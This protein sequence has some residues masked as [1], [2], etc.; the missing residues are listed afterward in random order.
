MSE[1]RQDLKQPDVIEAMKVPEDEAGRQRI[2][3]WAAAYPTPS[4]IIPVVVPDRGQHM[5]VHTA[6]GTMQASV[7]DWVVRDAEGG[8]HP[9]K[10]GVLA[11]ICEETAM[12]DLTP[13]EVEIQSVLDTRYSIDDVDAQTFMIRSVL[14]QG[15]LTGA[16]WAD[17]NPPF[18]DDED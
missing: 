7:G 11:A 14:R 2:Q 12:S 6:E 1:S 8:F 9:C 15:F 17:E 10:S 5:L 3:S 13:R 18:D 16:Q 4:G